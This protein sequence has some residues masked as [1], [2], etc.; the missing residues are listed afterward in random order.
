MT[1]NYTNWS[2]FEQQL[3]ADLKLVIKNYGTASYHDLLDATDF[4]DVLLK[5]TLKRVIKRGFIQHHSSEDNLFEHYTATTP[6]AI[7]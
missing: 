5:R 1:S 7:K 2:G 4:G 3:F 6:H